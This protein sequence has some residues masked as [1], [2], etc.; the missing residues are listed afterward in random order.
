MA[1]RLAERV[2]NN[3]H[4]VSRTLLQVNDRA[5]GETRREDVDPGIAVNVRSVKAEQASHYEF[6]WVMRYRKILVIGSAL[7]KS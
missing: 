3:V 5:L 1:V 7:G 4:F 6:F 2:L